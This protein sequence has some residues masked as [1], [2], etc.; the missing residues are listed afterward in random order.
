MSEISIGRAGVKE[1]RTLTR[2]RRADG[3]F[4]K[5]LRQRATWREG[6]AQRKSLAGLP[7]MGLAP[8]RQGFRLSC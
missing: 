2:R 8:M 1:H 5:P 6:L 3:V 4:A 7:F